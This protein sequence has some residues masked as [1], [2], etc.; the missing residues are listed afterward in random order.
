MAYD[1]GVQMVHRL[2][3]GLSSDRELMKRARKDV[4]RKALANLALTPA[5]KDIAT[6]KIRELD[7][8]IEIEVAKRHLSAGTYDEALAAIGRAKSLG[9]D[10]RLGLAENALRY[11]PAFFRWCYARYVQMLHSFKRRHRAGWEKRKM[12]VLNTKATRAQVV[13]AKQ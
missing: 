12:S 11:C 7:K 6:S 4:Y 1:S 8:E 2:T 9:P 5:Q 10:R 13:I 3:T